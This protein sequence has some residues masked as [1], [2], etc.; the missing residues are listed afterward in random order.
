MDGTSLTGLLESA[1][2]SVAPRRPRALAATAL[3]GLVT[4]AT[5]G[6]GRADPPPPSTPELGPLVSGTSSIVSGTFVWTDYAYD[7]RGANTVET[8]IVGPRG[9][10]PGS[11]A[12][13]GGDAVYPGWAAPGNTADLIQLQISRPPEGLAIRAI[14]E[15]LVDPRLPILG[16][17][18]DSDANPATGATELP[19]GR[20]PAPDALGIDLLAIVSAQGAVLLGYE[21][22]VWTPLATRQAVVDPDTNVIQARFDNDSLPPTLGSWRVFGVLGLVNP[23]TGGS[24]VDGSEPIFDLAFVGN[25]PQV[26]WQDMRQSDILV[27]ALP[28]SQAAAEIDFGA[29][30]SGA[31]QLVDEL[32]PGFKT[33]LY[34]SRLGLPEGVTTPVPDVSL[35]QHEY[36]GPYQP[37]QVFVPQ[38]PPVGN[39]LL[40]SLHGSNNNHMNSI[41]TVPN[42]DYVGTSRE[43][44]ED[45][46]LIGLFVPDFGYNATLPATSKVWP[47][48]RGET[49]RYAGISEIDVLEVTQDAVRRLGTDPE[50]VTLHGDS[51]GGYGAYRLGVRYPDHWAAIIP[52][53]GGGAADRQLFENLENVPVRQINGVLDPGVLIGPAL[54]DAALLDALGLEFRFWALND[55]GHDPSANSQCVRDQAAVFVRDTDP[56]RVVYVVDPTTFQHDPTRDVDIVYDSAYWVSGIELGDAGL[57]GRVEADSAA[58]PHSLE[59]LVRDDVVLGNTVE[60]RDLCGPNPLF[61]PGWSPAFPNGETWREISL[62]REPGMPEPLANELDAHLENVAAVT[63]DLARAGFAP[64]ASGVVR[65]TSDVPV[66]ITLSGLRRRT[67][68]SLGELGAG[69]A[70]KDGRVTV[71][72]GAGTHEL[73]VMP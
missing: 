70:K 17:A 52:V 34:H 29:L 67:G 66:A 64:D 7:D 59:T 36:L 73:V 53:I 10:A 31:S 19:G 61:A 8:S 15:T 27:G 4:L 48:G 41:F 35:G 24:W 69:R 38:E 5:G 56:S 43:F 50:R 37:Y 18:F 72:L 39:P 9:A 68:V 23:G 25:E 22:G 58:R 11:A 60:A 44:S 47:L 6:D 28:S 45:P 54:E 32:A 21:S 49:L 65:V 20:W 42:G 57:P 1:F 12:R 16:V 71:A 30:R 14:L 51:M 55:R 40:V 13:S 3:A 33:F 46:F 2:P 63:L 26:Q 62:V